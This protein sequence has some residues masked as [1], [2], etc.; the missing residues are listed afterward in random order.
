MDWFLYDN[1]LRHEM[2]NLAVNHSLTFLIKPR[3]LS[4]QVFKDVRLSYPR[5]LR[6]SSLKCPCVLGVPSLTCPGILRFTYPKLLVSYLFL[7]LTCPVSCVYVSYVSHVSCILRV[8]MHYVSR[9]LCV[10]C[11]QV[12]MSLSLVCPGSPCL[13]CPLYGKN[14][15]NVHLK[16]RTYIFRVFLF[17]KFYLLF[18]LC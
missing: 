17:K 13:T 18:L 1:G 6:V 15:K 4:L 9:V 5:V 16:K 10:L 7:C 3:S 11:P 8:H 12:L 14:E 2:V